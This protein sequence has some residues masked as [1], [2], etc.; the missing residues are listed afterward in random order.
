MEEHFYL[1]L[2]LLFLILVVTSR[3]NPERAFALMPA[4]FAVVGVTCLIARYVTMSRGPVD[5][6]RNIEPTHLRI[7]SLFFGVLLS[8]LWNV[9]GLSE[10]SLHPVSRYLLG[11]IGIACFLPAFLL[12]LSPGSWLWTLGLTGF[13][14]GA[15]CL[16]WAM[17]KVE[18]R[19]KSPLA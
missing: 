4:C 12:E 11:G 16:L 8:Y 2:S 17:L 7:D 1:F 15:G 14:L 13:Y 19:P 6:L 18:I 5:Y 10:R 3:K 9:R